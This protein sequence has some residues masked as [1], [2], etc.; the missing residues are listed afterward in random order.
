MALHQVFRL[1]FFALVKPV[2]LLLG[3][4]AAQKVTGS[5]K[6]QYCQATLF[7][8]AAGRRKMVKEQFFTKNGVDRLGQ[9]GAFTRPETAVIAKKP[10]HN[11]ICRVVKFERE[12]HQFGTGVKQ[13][14][15]MH[16]VRLSHGNFKQLYR[17]DTLLAK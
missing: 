2:D 9:G 15:W 13:G 6:T 17:S 11:G 7:G 8:A 16:R 3:Q 12:A 4:G 5:V 10:R 14:F 1:D